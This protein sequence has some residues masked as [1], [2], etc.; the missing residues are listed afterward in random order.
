[1]TVHGGWVDVT[2]GDLGAEYWYR[3]LRQTVRFEEA[4]RGLLSD[5]YDAFVECSPH[6]VLTM[7]IEETA[8]ALGHSG[9]VAVGSLRREEGGLERL[10]ASFAEAHVHGITVDW[11]RLFAGQDAHRVDLPTY[12]FQ[13]QRYWVDAAVGAVGDVVSAGLGSA[14]H[15]LLGAAV[16]LAGGD[17]FLFTGRLS[18]RTHPWLADHTVAGAVLVP[19]TGMLELALRAGEQVGFDHVEELTLAAPLVVPER[20]GVQIQLAVGE[21]DG[22]GRRSLTL[23]SRIDEEGAGLAG[24]WVQHATGVLSAEPAD[25]QATAAEWA[26]WPPQD[27]VAVEVADVYPGLAACGFA[28][29]PVF[30]GL[31]AAWRWGEEVF[32]EV[33][34]PAEE[35]G[36]AARFGIHPALLDSA[37]HGAAVA[38]PEDEMQESGAVQG[39]LPFSWSGVSLHAVGA[40]ALRVRLTPAGQGAV[41]VRVA[42]TTGTPVASIDSLAF[43][44]VSAEQLEAARGTGRDSLFQLDWTVLP[45]PANAVGTDGF[46]WLD[47]APAALAGLPGERYADLTALATAIDAGAAVP[48]TVVLP[49]TTGTADPVTGTRESAA[50]VLAV[51]QAWVA[52]ER[53]ADSRLLLV[54]QGAVAA[55]RGADVPD[56]VAASVWGLVRSAQS[57][58]PDRI[59]LADVDGDDASGVLPWA[60]TTGEPQLA[61]RAGVLSVPRLARAAG[62]AAEDAEAAFG[63]DGTVLLTGAT[64]TLGALVARH[65]VARHGVRHLLLASR[66]GEAAPG[67]AELVAELTEAGAQVTLAA[68]DVADRA[69]LVELLAQIPAEAPLTGVVHTAAVLDDGVIES[70][71]AERFDTVLR[72]K[73]DA[74]WYLHELTRDLDLSAFVLFSSAA[75]TFG[76]AGQGNYAAANTFVDALAEHRRAHGLPAVSLAWGFWQELSGLTGQLN[77]NDLRRA[78]RGGLRGLTAQE[79]LALF[80]AACATDVPALVPVQ[81]DLAAFRSQ[82]AAA[83]DVPAL[84]RGLVR[85]P[86]RRVAAADAGATADALAQRL[87][88]APEAERL[89]VVLEVVRSQVAAVLGFSSAEMVEEGRAF[90]ELGFDSLLAV[91]LRNRLNAA[92]A[93]R[94]PPTLVFDYPTP[95]A[96]ARFL[97]AEVRQEGGARNEVPISTELDKL[98]AEISAMTLDDS[99]RTNIKARLEVLLAKLSDGQGDTDGDDLADRLMSASD[100]EIFRMIDSDFDLS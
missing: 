85:I 88:A 99:A 8:E 49:V 39:Q 11:Q 76:A 32:A 54:T 60:L 36:Q 84:F 62:A 58:Y 19:G 95:V 97:L 12:A 83:G 96:M 33:A 46:A 24:E 56:L 77:E 21:S 65:L 61:V 57:E 22:T 40:A 90:K 59:V 41:S 47:A 29:G 70:L 66:S 26:V 74:S 1:S 5:G 34:L 14:D 6:P 53:W 31:R 78:T 75:G 82:A 18:L 63:P 91:E 64:G 7:G 9:L 86:A 48:K 30:Q 44:Q 52:D 51:V 4:V 15:P 67:A 92:T 71:T 68:C 80:D 20:G 93:L 38:L 98:D 10:L 94:L 27:A 55:E 3:N 13:R 23:H 42:D 45:V 69:A 35:H 89:R 25:R 50:H 2:A 28:Y 81:L 87:A 17:G 72:P 43:R 16:G 37:L 100:D 73:V 79:G